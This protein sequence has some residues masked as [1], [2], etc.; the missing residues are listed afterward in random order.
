M[1]TLKACFIILQIYEKD[2][3][4]EEEL[5][6]DYSID[7]IRNIGLVG[8]GGSGKTSITEAALFVGKV[9]TRLGSV[10]SGNTVTDYADDEIARKISIGLSLAH[11]DWKGFKINLIDMPGYTDFF[12]EVVCGL[13][14]ADMALVA[15]NGVTGPEVGTDMVW[16]LASKN[17]LPRA[18]FI[19]RLD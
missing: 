1:L 11:L 9:T 15:I 8:H 17:T 5:M 3:G 7:K 12:G 18:F 4:L 6:K 16:R 13:R 14:A 2:N 19:N 10:D